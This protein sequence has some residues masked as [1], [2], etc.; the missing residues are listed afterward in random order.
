[1]LRLP[2]ML[3]LVSCWRIHGVVRLAIGIWL[4]SVRQ[5]L[6]VLTCE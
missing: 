6:A 1:M 2:Q 5:L 3:R 4:P